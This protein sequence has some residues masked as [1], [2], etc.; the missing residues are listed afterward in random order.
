M[1]QGIGAWRA[2][3]YENAAPQDALS[4]QDHSSPGLDIGVY[5]V[6]PILLIINLLFP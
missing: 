2:R 6:S 3:P 4:W 1:W 5:Q